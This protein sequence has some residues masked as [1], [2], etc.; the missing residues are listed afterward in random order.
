[1]RPPNLSRQGAAHASA[2][3]PR[4]DQLL[5]H[6]RRDRLRLRLSGLILSQTLIWT[7]DATA[8]AQRAATAASAAIT[9]LPFGAVLGW[10][11]VF[12]AACAWACLHQF[13]RHHRSLAGL[14]GA[15]TGAAVAVKLT[16][17]HGGDIALLWPLSAVLGLLTGLGVWMIAY[18]R[19]KPPARKAALA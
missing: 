1:M 9:A 7:D 2:A 16:G 5:P 18:G 15:A 6:R 8:L 4:D 17:W 13:G 19:R 10:P 12:C 3:R 11:Y 14:I